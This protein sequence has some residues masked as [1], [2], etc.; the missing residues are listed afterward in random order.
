M[1]SSDAITCARHFDFSTQHAHKRY[2]EGTVAKGRPRSKKFNKTPAVARAGYVS[3]LQPHMSD[4]SWAIRCTTTKIY[5][6]MWIGANVSTLREVAKSEM[7]ALP[8]STAAAVITMGQA[9]MKVIK[10]QFG[11][12]LPQVISR[13]ASKVK[14]P[15]YH[16]PEAEDSVAFHVPPPTVQTSSTSTQAVAPITI[17]DV[18]DEFNTITD[19]VDEQHMQPSIEIPTQNESSIV[20]PMY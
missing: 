15:Q 10:L 13:A 14:R 7:S 16:I 18:S 4:Q 8:G 9:I 5:L 11:G 3:S 6:Y 12:L 1:I 19:M 2:T 20:E 17:D